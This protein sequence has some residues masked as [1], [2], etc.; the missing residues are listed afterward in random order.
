MTETE[1]TRTGKIVRLISDRGFGFIKPDG[2]GSDIFFHV[3]GL[4]DVGTFEQLVEGDKLNY[5]EGTD[6]RSGKPR[7]E[8]LSLV[9]A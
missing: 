2:G 9:A 8:N 5:T 4:P 3:T 6:Q 1:T 7:A